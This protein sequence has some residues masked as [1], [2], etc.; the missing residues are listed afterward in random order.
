IDQ[1]FGKDRISGH[2]AIQDNS[3]YTYPALI[4][5]FGQ[6]TTIR[7][8]NAKISDTHI[9]TPTMVL[10]ARISWNR[11]FLFQYTPRNAGDNN[12]DARS[13]LHMVIPSNFG[14]GQIQNNIPYFSATSFAPVG[15][16]TGGSPLRQPDEVQQ[17]AAGLTWVRGKHNLKFG[18]DLRHARS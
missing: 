15:D 3:N 17:F 4:R 13:A 1:S 5:D 14:P 6:N 9:F 2:Y 10:D 7:G 12:Y 18:T 8:Q 11:D 16:I